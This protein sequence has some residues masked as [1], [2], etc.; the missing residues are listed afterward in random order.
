MNVPFKGYGK[1]PC[2]GYC[3]ELWWEY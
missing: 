3:G 2:T 1:K